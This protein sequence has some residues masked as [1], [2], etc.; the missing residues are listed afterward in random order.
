MLKKGRALAPPRESRMT[1]IIV[2][3][4]ELQNLAEQKDK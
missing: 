2:P 4:E 3:S 1:T